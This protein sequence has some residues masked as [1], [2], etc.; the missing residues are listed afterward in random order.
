MS[1]CEPERPK[2]SNVSIITLTIESSPKC[3][4]Q[5][6]DIYQYI[7]SKLAFLDKIS[8]ELEGHSTQ[9][10]VQDCFLKPPNL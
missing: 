8:K 3:S 5:L 9:Y 7:L 1:S 6:A 2:L 4:L 10:A